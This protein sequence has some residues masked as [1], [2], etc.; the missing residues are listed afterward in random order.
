[1]A[2]GDIVRF[3]LRLNLRN[4][5]HSRIYK[6]LTALDKNVH[7]S[8]NQ[9]I[10]KAIDFYIQSFEDDV[11]INEVEQKKKTVTMEDL[12]DVRKEIESG[13]KDE[14][15]RLFGSII[16]GSLTVREKEGRIEPVQKE[17]TEEHNIFAMEAANRW[18]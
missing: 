6:V 10:L 13:L 8:E 18:G 3:S 12:E 14:L 15:I 7:K 4:E 2:D 5:Q 9:F 1:M 16:T 11:I 17:E